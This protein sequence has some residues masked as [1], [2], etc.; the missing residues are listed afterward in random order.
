[1]ID[2]VSVTLAPNLVTNGGF[3]DPDQSGAPGWAPFGENETGLTGWTVGGGGVQH[4]ST[5]IFPAFPD[6]SCQVMAGTD[7]AVPGSISQTIDTKPGAFYIISFEHASRVGEAQLKVDFGGTSSV[8]FAPITGQ[9]V[10]KESFSVAAT[11]SS[12]I[13][14]FT[15][16][17]PGDV[18]GNIPVLDNVSVVKAL[19]GLVDPEVSTVMAWQEYV[20]ADGLSVSTVTV[21]LT[22]TSGVPVSDKTVSLTK[23]SGPGEPVITAINDTTGGGGTA[24]FEVTSTTPGAVEF[25]ATDVTDELVITQTVTV[26]LVEGAANSETS[27]VVAEPA[28]VAADGVAT[29]TIKVTLKNAS[30]EPVAGKEV[31]LANAGGTADPVIT[32]VSGTTNANGEATF[33]VASTVAGT[34]EL[35]AKDVTDGGIVITETASVGFVPGPVDAETSTVEAAPP[36]APA[37]DFT[38]VTITVTLRDAV[39]NGVEGRSVDLVQTGGSASPDIV[40]ISNVT[41]ASGVATF[42]LSSLSIGDAELTASD[43]TDE[44][45]VITETVTV[46]FTS[47]VNWLGLAVIIVDDSD[48]STNG[49]LEYAEHWAGV[50]RVVNGVPFTAAQNNVVASA[51]PVKTWTHDETAYPQGDLSDN[52]W[53]ILRGIWYGARSGQ[54]VS[55]LNLQDGAK[56]EVQIWSSDPRYGPNAEQIILPGLSLGIRDGH[57]AVGDF[58][59]TGSTQILSFAGN[60]IVNAIQVRNLSAIAISQGPEEGQ[61]TIRGYSESGGEVV[62]EKTTSLESPIVW[63]VVQTN[64]VE[65]GNFSFTILQGNDEAAY[66]RTKNQ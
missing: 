38:V 56:Y 2:N 32:T 1:V 12:T 57:Y 58:T 16:L 47:L 25:T 44:E 13:L 15:G 11:E 62:T 3:E 4:F 50:D 18:A 46:T 39:G 23:T 54:Y 65:A 5:K 27:T 20:A 48:V 40:P 7:W 17:I 22:D 14:M 60:G 37:D 34:A 51:D 8:F 63:T 6:Q 19:S 64:E 33:T 24:V 30:D 29:Y 35:Q 52:Y 53:D 41:D 10:A 43:V 26:N 45:R 28:E 31:T 59:A 9:G 66:F 49:I 55:L 21:T 36:I 61:L 42:E